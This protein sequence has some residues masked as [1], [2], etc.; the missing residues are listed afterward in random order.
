[1]NE[2]RKILFLIVTSV[3]CLMVIMGAHYWDLPMCVWTSPLV[4]IP[5]IYAGIHFR[6]SGSGLTAF[7]LLI[8]Q[9]PVILI[10][11]SRHLDQGT[12]YFVSTCLA[13]IFS[14]YVG[15]RQRKS[16]EN[17]QHLIKIHDTVRRIQR[18]S[19]PK[20]LLSDLEE[21]VKEIGD[22]DRAEICMIDDGGVLREYK[23]GE[24]VTP[25][26]HVYYKVL[27]KRCF[28]V[29]NVAAEDD[30]FEY[31]G[32]SE[33]RGAVEQFS[34]FPIEYGG[35]A[36]GVVSLI[37]S[38]NN[39]MGKEE[40]AFLN[41]YKKSIETALEA[42]EKREARIQHEMQK[43]R[44]RDT[45]SSYVSRSV[46]E[47]ILKDPDRLELGGKSRNV[48]VMF[49]EIVNFMDLQKTVDPSTLFAALN[50]CF[51]AAI[52]TVFEYDGTLDKFI[53]DGV[54]A[55]WGAPIPMQDSESRAVDCA[56]SLTEKIGDLNARWK[57]EGKEEFIFSIGINSGEVVAGNI[58]SIRR[59]EYTIIGDTVN[60]AS[61]IISLSKSKSI[62]ILIGETTYEKVKNKVRIEERYE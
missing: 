52:D 12:K 14:I 1:M 61:R 33:D 9:T 17:S 37:N 8:A 16:R 7:V 59:M 40:V 26:D 35:S 15:H 28:V 39:R 6:R 4:A 34:V 56:L 2:K 44:I 38:K 10:Y 20:S 43:K 30:R 51:T 45:F 49:T 21:Q 42:V 24:E 53:G 11:A 60:T 18:N 29:S 55:F 5:V 27:E 58:G 41:A 32:G 50:E 54:M 31:V 23:T 22:S 48:T 36:K 57:R 46:A 3:L 47:E 13:A 25:A 19:E 62:P